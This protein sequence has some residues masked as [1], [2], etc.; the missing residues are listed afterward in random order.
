MK[1]QKSKRMNSDVTTFQASPDAALAGRLAKMW[2]HREHEASA[3]AGILCR[4]GIH[5][6][7]RLDVEDM[8][9]GR[10][11]R[12]CFWCTKVSIDGVHYEP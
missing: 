12:F 4:L 9:P 7:R 1:V 10:K 8:V 3:V 5:F 2:P 6:W 11:V